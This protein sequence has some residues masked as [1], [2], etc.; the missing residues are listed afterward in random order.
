MLHFTVVLE[1]GYE[2]ECIVGKTLLLADR[3]IANSVTLKYLARLATN[4][5]PF[6][7]FSSLILGEPKEHQQ[8]VKT[9][10]SS[11]SIDKLTGQCSDPE[12]P[13]TSEPSSRC[14]G[15]QVVQLVLKWTRSIPPLNHLKTSDQRLL[16]KRA[17]HELF[18]L[19]LSQLDC[20]ISLGNTRHCFR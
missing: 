7:R 16:I 13:S 15:P 2:S 17:W 12:S 4:F 10:P 9:T 19:T 8:P 20:K 1:T 11:F 3:N 18:V 5:Y 6:S 14:H